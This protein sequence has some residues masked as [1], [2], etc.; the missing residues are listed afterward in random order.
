VSTGHIVISGVMNDSPMSLTLPRGRVIGI[1]GIGGNG[2][3]GL[4]Q[5]LTGKTASSVESIDVAGNLV[6]MGGRAVAEWFRG[7]VAVVPEDRVREGGALSMSV[8]E[9][10]AVRDLVI[11]RTVQYG[12]ARPAT[13]RSRGARMID[14]W[15]IRPANPEARFGELSGGNMQRVILARALDPPPELLVAVGV[16]HGLDHQSAIMVR[17]ELRVAADAGVTVISFEHDLD[18]ALRHSDVIGVMYGGRLSELL[19]VDLDA[20]ADVQRMMV[21]GWSKETR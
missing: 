15:R 18:E 10:L 8:A 17:D 4:D 6:H 1:V 5:L 13:L 19:P 9:N 12:V 20:R 7:N 3:R 2:Q 11:G 21:M 14:R 16:T